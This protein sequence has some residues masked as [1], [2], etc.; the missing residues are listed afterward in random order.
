MVT[1]EM[2]SRRSKNKSREVK[3]VFQK[4][5]TG[6]LTASHSLFSLLPQWEERN[7]SKFARN[8]EKTVLLPRRYVLLLVIMI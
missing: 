5:D 4:Y 1:G 2:E 8:S 3:A 6:L 7:I